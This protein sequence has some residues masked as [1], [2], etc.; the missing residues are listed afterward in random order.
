MP[1]KQQPVEQ[2]PISNNRVRRHNL[3]TL[4]EHTR[5][6]PSPQQAHQTEPFWASLRLD[7][8]NGRFAD[9][10]ALEVVGA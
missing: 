4:T 3:R 2:S 5:D 7:F 8:M 10:G 9:V 1:P 6:T